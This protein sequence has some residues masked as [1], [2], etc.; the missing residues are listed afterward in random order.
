VKRFERYLR[1]IIPAVP[2][3]SRMPV[4]RV[5]DFVDWLTGIP[6]KEARGLPPNRYRIRIGVGNRLLFNQFAFSYQGVD[7][8]LYVFAHGM[9][10]LSSNIVDIGCGC[11]RYAIP[12]SR[13]ALGQETFRGRY[14]GIDVDQEMVDWCGKHFPSERFAFDHADIQNTV[15]NPAGSLAPKDYSIPVEDSSQD[16]VFS[17]SVFTHLLEDGLQH[18]LAQAYRILR[19]GG[20]MVGSVFCL[21][22]MAA[23]LGG[24]WTF[25]H[26][27]G[28]AMV[29]TVEYPEAA[30]AYEEAHLKQLCDA[31]GFQEMTMV[32]GPQQSLLQC[33]K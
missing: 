2:V 13:F 20:W 4:V 27:I 24:R 11:G 19:P 23:S 1:R 3:F 5:L 31:L 6:F 7:F 22:S 33:R 10:D 32:W 17:N 29:E 25:R 21:E 15:Y 16:L 12:L 28:K 8:W 14:L 26:R 9:A 18:Y 30:V